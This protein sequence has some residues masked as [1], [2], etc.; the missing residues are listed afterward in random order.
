MV[1]NKRWINCLHINY[2]FVLV[3][4]LFFVSHMPFGI[5]FSRKKGTLI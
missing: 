4:F 3:P 1:M 5:C 2:H